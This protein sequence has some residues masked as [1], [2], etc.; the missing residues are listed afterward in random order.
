M[1]SCFKNFVLL[2]LLALTVS[3]GQD[4]VAPGLISEGFDYS[5]CDEIITQNTDNATFQGLLQNGASSSDPFTV[6]IEENVTLGADG[7]SLTVNKN[8]ILMIGVS[9]TTSVVK[10]LAPGISNATL[11][12]RNLTLIPATA[13]MYSKLCF[14]NEFGAGTFLFDKIICSAPFAHQS[15]DAAFPMSLNGGGTVNLTISN[16]VI[17]SSK[18]AFSGSA[19]NGATILATLT[20][21]TFTVNASAI[22]FSANNSGVG[23]VN[24]GGNTMKFSG[25]GSNMYNDAVF[26]FG[27]NSGSITVNDTSG[28]QKNFACRVAGSVGT[29]SSVFSISAINGASTGGTFTAA[30]TQNGGNTIGNCP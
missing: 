22:W 24:A 14:A 15:M 11:Y 9:Q 26:A 3:C 28:S 20:N 8:N 16:S 12:V 13:G 25:N 6:C 27:N 2:S 4:G 1:V 17:S 23:V 29:F 10:G 5:I 19:N 7:S 21:N 18:Y 30:G